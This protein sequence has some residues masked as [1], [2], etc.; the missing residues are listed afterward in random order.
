M[1]GKK[2]K[3]YSYDSY[4]R[5]T[6]KSTNKKN[7]NKEKEIENLEDTNTIKIDDERLND[8]ETLDTSFLEGRIEKKVK[9]NSKIKQKILTNLSD[10]ESL[11]K[12]IFIKKLFFCISLFFLILFLIS[13]VAVFVKNMNLDLS[14]DN[15]KPAPVEKK[16]NTNTK[17]V[18]DDNYLFIGDNNLV[19]FNF[20][21]YG[22]DYHYVNV[23]ED[24]LTTNDI[25]LDMKKYVYDYNPTKIFISVGLSDLDD[26]VSV[27]K[28]I[29]N[30]SKIVKQTNINRPYAEIY[31]QSVYPINKDLEEYDDE[32]IR[33][34]LDNDDI[35]E[36][37]T[38]LK[39]YCNDKN[40]TYVDT[41]SFLVED[42]KLNEKYTDNGIYLNKDGYEQVLKEINKIVR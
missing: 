41:Y 28:I 24:D 21:D 35:T 5:N 31:I 16:N 10:N 33:D 40:L 22:L 38:A 9:K 15:P 42:G 37:N 4:N 29:S 27:D 1:A 23:S 25:L 12:V 6:K 2:K 34:D 18:I 20:G 17:K 26:E 32:I 11:K 8:Y 14:I 19:R 3:P 30:I 36:L 13:V 39:D 7:N